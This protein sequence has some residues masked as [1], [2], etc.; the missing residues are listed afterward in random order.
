MDLSLLNVS[1]VLTLL[2]IGTVAGVVEGVKRLFDKDYRIFAVI[3]SSGLVGG[4]LGLLLPFNEVLGM[5]VVMGIVIGF[6]AT[7]YVT[8]AQGIGKESY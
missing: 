4:L 1:P 5:S 2:A 8:I 7:G 6:S 3:L